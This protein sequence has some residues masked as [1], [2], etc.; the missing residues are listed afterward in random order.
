MSHMFKFT[1]VALR[2][3]T[4]LTLA[5]AFVLAVSRIDAA[6]STNAEL[7][8]SKE[9][10]WPQFRGPRRDGICDERGLLREWPEG[11]PKLLWSVKNLG[12]GFS[13]PIIAGD[14]LFI[15][16][17]V[18]EELHIFALDL[19]GRLLWTAKNGAF[20]RDPYPGARASVAF[21]E[22]RIFH[23]NAHGRLACFEAASG[24]EV[25]AVDLLREFGGENITWGLSECVLVDERAVYATAGG[26]EALVVALDKNTGKLLW[27]SAPLR[28]SEGEQKI[29]NASY[30]S[31]ILVQFAG[32]RLLVGCSLKHLFCVDADSGKIQWTRRFPT[33]YSVISM[34]PVLV[35]NGIFMTAPHGKAGRFLNLLPPKT[36]GGPVAMEEG[37][38]TP[39]DTLQG[40]AVHVAGKL[41]GSFYPGRKGWAAIDANTGKVLYDAPEIVKGAVLYADERLHVLSEDGTMLL[42]QAGDSQ[43]EVKGRFQLAK[44]SGRDAWAHPVI[45]RKKLYLRYHDA[46]SCYDIAENSASIDEKTSGSP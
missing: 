15:T 16:G 4:L 21:S 39:L 26:S 24:K 43:F 32:R 28:D 46:L 10:G 30:V 14:R 11:G 3:A 33:T 7:I 25:W 44:A 45:H 37:W 40:G 17:D 35:G 38:T 8:A 29:E 31:P 20:W 36:A 19:Q 12:R 5:A 22:G 18:G 42:L 9:E 27:K 41:F 6:D 2:R 23:E 34:M 13:S 1:R